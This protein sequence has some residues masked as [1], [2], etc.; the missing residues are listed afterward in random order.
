MKDFLKIFD[1]P[2]PVLSASTIMFG[3]DGDIVRYHSSVP[4]MI[5]EAYILGYVSEFMGS[6]PVPGPDEKTAK[7]IEKSYF[8]DIELTPSGREFCGL[9]P[10]IPVV[11]VEK[12]NPAKT[13]IPQ[14]TASLFDDE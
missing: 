8:M 3:V 14:K 7:G 5:H 1:C 9:P 11:V 2:C 6:R 10:V 4:G 13:K 12:K